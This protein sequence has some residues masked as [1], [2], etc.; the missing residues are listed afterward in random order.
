MGHPLSTWQVGATI[1]VVDVAWMEGG[2]RHA[3]L[4]IEGGR[5]GEVAIS[6]TAILVIDM[7][8]G[9]GG[10]EEQAVIVLCWSCHPHC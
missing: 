9:K 1:L 5:E 4:V 2:R 10:R 7:A 6:I 3:A 8:Q